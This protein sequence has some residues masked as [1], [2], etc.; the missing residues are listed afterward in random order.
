[1]DLRVIDTADDGSAVF[2]RGQLEGAVG[3]RELMSASGKAS[4]AQ[5]DS[6]ISAFVGERDDM[7]PPQVDG[8]LSDL[9]VAGV[10]DLS[11]IPD[12]K[13][14]Q[15][16]IDGGFGAQ[17]IASQIVLGGPHT[18]TLPLARSFAFMGQRYVLDSEV[19][20]NVVYDRVL[21]DGA[22][23]RTSQTVTSASLTRSGPA[24]CKA[25][26]SRARPGFRMRSCRKRASN[27][28]V[29]VEGNRH[30]SSHLRFF[31]VLNGILQND[32]AFCRQLSR[33]AQHFGCAS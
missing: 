10:A 11:D 16:V 5:I 17:R 28:P 15:A 12:E 7:T 4:W 25:V 8:L 23:K 27:C 20:S 1:M 2:R 22:P 13:L 32:P 18:K 19:F 29:I 30:Q 3:L 14:A 31:S 24:F 33:Y 26:H 21:H 9:G 6:V